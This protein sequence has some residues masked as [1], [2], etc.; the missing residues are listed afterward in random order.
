ML[1]LYFAHI[2]N[3]LN[4]Y[5]SMAL[6]VL[7]LIGLQK[8]L[9]KVFMAGSV[10]LLLTYSAAIIIDFIFWPDL[11]SLWKK[12]NLSGIFL[13]GVPVEELFWAFLFGG[14]WPL[15][16]LYVTGPAHGE[17]RWR[18]IRLKD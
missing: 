10:A 3:Y 8:G 9:W 12:E 2:R 16:Y 13:S 14:T 17:Y 6:M 15:I 7:L 4:S 1:L 11:I 5:L 18:R